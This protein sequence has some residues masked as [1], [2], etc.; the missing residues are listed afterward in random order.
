ME[1]GGL[2]TQKLLKVFGGTEAQLLYHGKVKH[3]PDIQ[4]CMLPCDE[5]RR[6]LLGPDHVVYSR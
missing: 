4:F 1:G 6:Q 5:R 2:V 3:Q